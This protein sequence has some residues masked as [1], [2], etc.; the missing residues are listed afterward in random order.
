MTKLTIKSNIAIFSLI[1]VMFLTL[2]NGCEKKKEVTD[3]SL[4]GIWNINL[5]NGYSGAI[6]LKQDGE[7]LFGTFREFGKTNIK[8]VLSGKITGNNVSLKLMDPE[9]NDSA[10]ITATVS[11]D[12][13]S[14][15]WIHN[16]QRET[17]EAWKSWEPIKK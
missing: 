2:L 1:A 17:M 12:K 10:K 6:L 4:T 15:E 11:G 3:G 14:G 7:D 13:M 9:S 16:N 8:F 5:S